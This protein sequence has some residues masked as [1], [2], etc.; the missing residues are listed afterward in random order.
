MLWIEF[1]L[2]LASVA[3]A[4]TFPSVGSRWFQALEASFSRLARRRGVSVLLVGVLALVSRAAALPIAP[5]PQPVIQDE[6]SYLLAAD[7]FARGRLT[8][9][10]LRP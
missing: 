4:F 8:S 3:I 9:Q 5:V 7:T 1:C 6:F 10:G 2:V